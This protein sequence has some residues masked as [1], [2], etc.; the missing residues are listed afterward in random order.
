MSEILNPGEMRIILKWPKTDPVT[1]TDLDSHLQIPD[2]ASSTFHVYAPSSKSRFY[3][4][5][6]S[7]DCNSC[8][9]NQLSDNVTLDKDHNNNSDPASPP[10]DETITISKVR[11]GTYSFSVHNFTNR[12]NSS[13]TNL[14]Q[15]GAKVKVIYC[16]VGAD[17]SNEEAVVRKEYHVKNANGTLWRVFTFNSSDSGSGFTRVRTMTYESTRGNIY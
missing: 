15:S 1:G 13:K 8:S 14:G 3:Y 11:S 6:N 4:A 12:D 9:S 7:K 2:N 10:G 17:C 5:T 16:P